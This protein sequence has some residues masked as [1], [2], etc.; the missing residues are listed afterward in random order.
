MESGGH[1]TF[2]PLPLCNQRMGGPAAGP[3]AAASMDLSTL[4]HISWHRTKW[5]SVGL[6]SLGW[7]LGCGFL[8]SHSCPPPHPS[9][10]HTFL[11]HPS[12]AFPPHG[13]WALFQCQQRPAGVGI[14]NGGTGLCVTKMHPTAWL[15]STHACST[16]GSRP[17]FGMPF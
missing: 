11:F 16:G 15:K 10:K 7:G 8:C 13:Q 5:P 1:S 12:S 3:S 6:A 2:R 9:P 17:C 4:S 14:C